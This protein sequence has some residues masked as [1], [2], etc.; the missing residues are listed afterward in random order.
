MKLDDSDLL[1]VTLF[2]TSEPQRIRAMAAELHAHN[3]RLANDLLIAARDLEMGKPTPAIIVA[4]LEPHQRQ[5]EHTH[6]LA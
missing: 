4:E 3:R 5:K 1:G 2:R 6:V